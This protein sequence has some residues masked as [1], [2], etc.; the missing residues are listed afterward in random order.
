MPCHQPN[1]MHILNTC[2]LYILVCFICKVYCSVSSEFDS[3]CTTLPALHN[4]GVVSLHCVSP[5][6]HKYSKYTIVYCIHY[7]SFSVTI[8]PPSNLAVYVECIVY[9][10]QGQS[11]AQLRSARGG[12]QEPPQKPAVT[13]GTA[14]Q[15][16]QVWLLFHI[17][18]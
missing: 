17:W 6:M 7:G 3:I 2:I 15:R 14:V 12:I 4:M 13:S 16:D 18:M 8:Q 5:C 10:A 1:D 9:E 11:T